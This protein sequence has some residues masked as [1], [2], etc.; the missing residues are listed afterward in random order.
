MAKDHA[1]ALI[2]PPFTYILPLVAGIILHF[3]QPFSIFSNQVVGDFIGWPL[4]ALGL[5]LAIWAMRT[6][7]NAG[8]HYKINKPTNKIVSHGPFS[9]TRNPI[10]LAFN[11]IYLGIAFNLNELWLISFSP[12]AFLT[13]HYGVILKEEQYMESKLGKEYLKYKERVRRWI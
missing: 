6:M 3:I 10:Y 13:L 11:L 7:I 2:H 9:F 1:N 8:E 12:I 5:L 4:L